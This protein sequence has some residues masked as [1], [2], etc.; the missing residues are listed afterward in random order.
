MLKHRISS[1]FRDQ[2]K[3]TEEKLSGPNMVAIAS[4]RKK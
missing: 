1:S 4:Q 2:T 3:H